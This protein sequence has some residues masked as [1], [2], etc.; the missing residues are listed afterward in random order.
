MMN[1]LLYV[2]PIM[3]L[4]ACGTPRV[5][6]DATQTEGT[7]QEPVVTLEDAM[8]FSV[9]DKRYDEIRKQL[10][11]EAIANTERA[12][13]AYLSALELYLVEDFRGAL[14]ELSSSLNSVETAVAHVLVGVI[15]T[16]LSDYRLAA[17]HFNRAMELNPSSLQV[18]LPGVQEW[19]NSRRF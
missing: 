16:A 6:T 5:A 2:L 18:P 11:N 4:L 17:N 13:N 19:L 8:A 14:N 3:L 7:P 10:E 1:R 12:I 9:D 15:Y